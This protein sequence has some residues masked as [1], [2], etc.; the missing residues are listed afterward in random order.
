M[1]SGHTLL[2]QDTLS[3][4]ISKLLLLV[5]VLTLNKSEAGSLLYYVDAARLVHRGR[6]CC[7]IEGVGSGCIEVLPKGS[8]GRPSIGRGVTYHMCKHHFHVV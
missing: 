4:L 8:C 2:E 1:M 6:L 5:A 7:M 3:A